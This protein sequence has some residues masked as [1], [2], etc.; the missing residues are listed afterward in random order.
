MILKSPAPKIK[1]K[2]VNSLI[3]HF[4][5]IAIQ[6]FYR[7]YVHWDRDPSGL[8]VDP[9]SQESIAT[10]RDV[11]IIYRTLKIIVLKNASRR[12][13]ITGRVQIF[14]I[15]HLWQAIT[16]TNPTVPINPLTNTHFT[17]EQFEKILAR[18]VECD[19]I[20][21]RSRNRYR[22]RY[23]A[24]LC[25][26]EWSSEYEA[27]S[28]NMRRFEMEELVRGLVNLLI[29]KTSQS[30]D[31]FIEL[32]QNFSVDHPIDN[33]TGRFP[34]LKRFT[35]LQL[36]TAVGN[37]R[38]AVTLL[39]HGARTEELYQLRV[40]E[41]VYPLHIALYERHLELLQPLLFYSERDQ[42][43]L[44]SCLGTTLELADKLADECP[45]IYRLLLV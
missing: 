28:H 25:S 42:F 30:D 12:L 45:D 2:K 38:V 22:I 18:A 1:L 37:Y 11:R 15:D 9:V 10:G 23:A 43:E 4:A 40:R 19:V 32:I 41:F 20:K 5:A 3:R 8:P 21:K 14:D 36:A 39:E 33:T 27:T 31:Q 16:L 44:T 35:L 13:I 7:R 17:H 6:S 29:D 34:Y 26:T 24:G